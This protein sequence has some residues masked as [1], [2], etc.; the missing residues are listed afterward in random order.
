M[1]AGVGGNAGG[2]A[3]PWV[4]PRGRG[5]R[6]CGRRRCGRGRVTRAAQVW[7]RAWP[8]RVWAVTPGASGGSGVGDGRAGHVLG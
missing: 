2:A 3:G 8:A 7:P 5:R 6:G 4:E 1:A